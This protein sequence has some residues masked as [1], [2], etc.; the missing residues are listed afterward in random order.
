LSKPISLKKNIIASYISQIYIIL[1]G[2]V[3]LPFYISEIGAE[4]YGLVG[5]FAMLQ[6]LFT[7]L[8]FGLT[9]AISRETSRYRGGG[10]DLISYRKLYRILNVIFISVAIL[11][12]IVLT[13]FSNDIATKWINVSSLSISE[14][15]FSFKVMAIAIA[16]KWMGGLYRGVVSGFEDIIWLSSFS[17]LFSTVRFLGVFPVMWYFGSTPTVF[18]SFQFIIYLIEFIAL[19]LRAN[20][21]LPNISATQKKSLGWSFGVIKPILGFSVSIAFTSAIWI[22]V[23]NV[24]KMIISGL[25]SLEDYGY[26]SLAVTIA[27]GILLISQPISGAITPRMTKM[28]AENSTAD[29]LKIYHQSTQIIAIITGTITI[30]LA[31]FTEQI[32]YVWTGDYTIVNEVAP[33][34]RLYA[35]GY[36]VL[37][38]SAFPFYLQVA[39]GNLKLHVIGNLLYIILLLPILYLSIRTYGLIGAG[40]TWFFVNSFFFLSWTYIV[41]N[42]FFKGLH[43]NWLFNDIAKLYILPIIAVYF[44]QNIFFSD[45]RLNMF[46]WILFVGL[47]LL[48]LSSIS[49]EFIRAKFLNLYKGDR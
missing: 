38:I 20:A 3:I 40:Y 25:V 39:L 47:L 41:H 9:P 15:V 8:D 49:S 10:I 5:F 31:G 14:V 2:I 44:L 16:I 26:F 35:I 48:F 13:L 46:F 21:L 18:F 45:S 43:W 30:V 37:A 7:L 32:L 42:K 1:L 28:V 17:A 27:G 34:M 36:G 29:M 24:D 22:L 11:G 19:Y 12:S 23:T 33:I 6:A 4:A